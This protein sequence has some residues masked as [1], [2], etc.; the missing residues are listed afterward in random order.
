MKTAL[1]LNINDKIYYFS[2]G[3]ELQTSAIESITRDKE[4]I[5]I[6]CIYEVLFHKDK[7]FNSSYRIYDEKTKINF[8]T[9]ELEARKSLLECLKSDVKKAN[10]E[11]EKVIAKQKLQEQFINDL[12]N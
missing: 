4:F 11:L 9:D 7:L 1:D 2:I 12:N 5:C 3:H 10:E 6:K 8:F